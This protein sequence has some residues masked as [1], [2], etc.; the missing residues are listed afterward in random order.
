L[1]GARQALL[2]KLGKLNADF[3]KRKKQAD[4][5]Y[6]RALVSLQAKA[7][8]NPE[9][10]K[11]LAAEKAAVMGQENA[12]AGHRRSSKG[13]DAN[14][15]IVNGGFDK[16][17]EGKADGWSPNPRVKVVAEDGNTFIRFH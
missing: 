5:D 15:M 17:T 4:A 8:E 6:L 13:A 11:Q 16:I 3:A 12:S 10:A 7:S 9:L 1:Q 2:A 14:N